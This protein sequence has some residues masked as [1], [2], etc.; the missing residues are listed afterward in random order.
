M[1]S[2]NAEGRGFSLIELLVTVAIVGILAAIAY[3][4]YRTQVETSRRA[5][6]QGELMAFAQYLERRYSQS[7]CYNSGDDNDCNEGNSGY[8]SLILSKESAKVYDIAVGPAIPVD[9]SAASDP[10]RFVIMATP[11]N[12]QAGTGALYIDHVGRRYWDEDDDGE[13]L[14]DAGE[15][16]WKR[17]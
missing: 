13:V 2:L 1:I 4:S 16:D 15:D 3:P 7:G 8:P 14:N 12:Q 9:S 6:L 11:K 10:S 5:E 17:G